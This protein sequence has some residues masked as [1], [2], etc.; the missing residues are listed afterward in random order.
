MMDRLASHGTIFFFNFFRQIN[1]SK[2]NSIIISVFKMF[3]N[4]S[5]VILASKEDFER[6][7]RR[8]ER[9]FAEQTVHN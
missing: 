6:E 4:D 9:V 7:L 8:F 2:F 5:S 3:L 1:F